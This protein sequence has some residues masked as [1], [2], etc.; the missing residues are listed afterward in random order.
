L[1][2]L[3][4]ATTL[5]RTYPSLPFQVFSHLL[6]RFAYG[7]N[8]PPGTIART[9]D[10]LVTFLEETVF[11]LNG[12]GLRGGVSYEGY[13]ISFMEE[14]N[15]YCCNDAETQI[16]SQSEFIFTALTQDLN[17]LIPENDAA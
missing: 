2:K 10:E 8:V 14:G 3:P 15:F 9:Q 7:Y 1:E 11:R 5:T 6:Y 4:P 17:F 12:D 13:T 16:G